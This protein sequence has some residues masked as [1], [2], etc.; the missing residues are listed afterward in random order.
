MEKNT[1]NLAIL[2]ISKS[3][4]LI[5]V[6]ILF[7]GVLNLNAQCGQ[8]TS[9]VACTSSAP[10]VIGNTISCT[11]PS[12]NAGR[13]NFVVNNMVAG[14]TYRIDNCGSGIDTQMTI[15]DALGGNALAYNDDDGPACNGTAAS[16][17]FTPT[18]T[19]TYYIQINKY[20]CATSP[21]TSNGNINV[22]YLTEPSCH[23]LTYCTNSFS[24][25][26][27]TITN[28]TFAGINNDSSTSN[29]SPE[30]E[31]FCYTGNVTKGSS[32][33]ISVNGVTNGYFLYGVMA[34][35][36]WNQDGDFEDSGE[37][38]TIGTLINNS[39]SGTPATAS[40]LVPSTATSGLTTMRVV[41]KYNSYATSC[42][43]SGYGQTEDYLVNVATSTPPTITTLNTVT[44]CPGSSLTIT[45]TNLS[46]ATS[47]TIGNTAATITAN[48]ATSITVTVGNGTTGTVKVTNSSGTATSL[49][50]YTVLPT[51]TITAQP[52]T[53]T[54]VC[55]SSGTRT[56][57]VTA[58]GATSYQWRRNGVNISNNSTYSGTT[59]STLT[60]TNPLLAIA[61]DFDVVISNG[62]CTNTSNAVTLTVNAAP[63]ITSNPSNS[64]ITAG[65]NTS[66]SITASNSPTSYSWQVSTNGGTSWTTISNGGVYSNATTATLN[67]TSATATMDGYLYKARA[68]NSCGN[69]SYS[70]S[71]TLTVSI[72]YCTPSVSSGKESSNYI[73]NVNF[74]GNLVNS[75]NGPTTYS[76]SPR[77]YQDWTSLGSRASQAQEEGVNIFV[78]TAGGANY[79]KAWVD[80]NKDGSFDTSTEVVYQCTNAFLNTTFGFQVPSNTVPGNYRIRL[81]INK[82]G[83]SNSY[84]SCESISYNGETEDYLFTVV[85]NCS[86][87]ITSI[88]NGYN[89]GTGSVALNAVGSS[90][91]TEYRWYTTETGGTYTSTTSTTWNTPSINST[92]TYYV[93]A[94]NGT[95]ESLYR[96]AVVATIKPVPSLTFSNSNPEICGENSII[97]LSASGTNE[98]VYLIDENF[99][100]S[101]ISFVNNEISS[102]NSSATKWQVRTSTYVPSYPTYPVWYPAISSGFGTNKFAMSTSDI[103]SGGTVNEALELISSISTTDFINLT[104]TFK[105]YFSSYYDSNNANNEGV[106]I[107]VNDGT[108]WSSPIMSYLEDEGIGTQFVTK[109]INM[110]AYINK[111][112]LKIRIRYRAGW[113]DG[114][115]VD[116][117][118]LYGDRPL[119]PNFTWTSG[120][121]IDAY[122]DAA[123]TIPYTSGTPIST[124]Y[125]K[126]TLEQLENLNYSFT[127]NANLANGCT[128]SG[129]VNVTNKTKIWKG[130]ENNDWNNANNWS[131]VG[132]PSIDNC[133]LVPD[134][135]TISG[136]GYNAYGKNLNVKSTGTLNVNSD[137]N[138][139]IAEEVIVSS[140]G[141]LQFENNASLIQI[142]N[143]A[144]SGNIIY[145]RAADN[146]KGS[147][148]VYWSSP[149]ANQAI[150]TIYSSPTSGPK[151]KWN[152]LVSNGNGANGNT[153]Q[154]N[155]AGA[156]GNTMGTATGY[157]VRG[158]SSFG[159]TATTINSTFTG[160]PNNGTITKEV[161][162]GS[163]TGATYNGA[164]GVAITNLDDNYNLIGNPYPSAINAL[165]FL[166]TNSSVLN[167]QVKL[168]SHGSSPSTS[169]SNQFYNT[170]AYNYS[171]SDYITIN[172][173]GSTT[174]GASEIIKAG[175]AFFV[176]MQDGPTTTTNVTFNNS[177]RRNASSNPYANNNFFKNSDT[178]KT[179]TN[180]SEATTFDAFERNRI[181][182]DI[183]DSNNN[184]NRA[185]IGYVSGATMAEDN[186][187]DA[188]S[189]SSSMRLYSLINEKEFLIQGRA[190]PFEDTDEVPL[191][192]S[193][194]TAGNYHIAINAIDGLFEGNQEIYLKD[195]LL[196]VYHDLKSA[197]YS[198]TATVG[199]HND[200][201]KLVYKNTVLSTTTFTENEVQIAK[202]NGI[203]DIVS[204]NETMQNVKVFDIR[205]RLIVE[206]NNVD[207]NTLSLDVNSVADQ[208]LI[209]NITTDENIK[210]VKKIL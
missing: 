111:S 17:D 61:G 24:N 21:N 134:S 98:Q 33:T 104:L 50:T 13:R 114:V 138:L 182:L 116:D 79:L 4:L 82:S 65:S 188:F 28:V 195:E 198:F 10:T 34:Y 157:I 81:R 106:F 121:P 137:N 207:N 175:Q 201:F 168:W 55:E 161:S 44:G 14:A 123:C 85:E 49:L 120:L 139:T 125:V 128:T 84:N 149:V 169:N 144:N 196:N 57:S 80:W 197:P 190:L 185:V 127:A 56:I 187:Y 103:T 26:V 22:T 209:V 2:K 150:N 72:S 118:K 142:N 90:G 152:T 29:S 105:M 73:T 192:F 124:V 12:S 206:K 181:W 191:G 172:F 92:T 204:G 141:T 32:Y 36:D 115:A 52:T 110:D 109:S 162:R 158:S 112:T 155:W 159:M 19:G 62:S 189:P 41:K 163:Y 93:T 146:I 76:S 178:N 69:S 126:P 27:R 140:G 88:T 47:V 87:K 6:L 7:F 71:A 63:S 48:T 54:S 208:V 160:V 37:S 133:V 51:P 202:N 176:I 113:C 131:P 180:N 5:T 66:F 30:H 86:A 42:N 74:I 1:P 200:R 194:S 3:K 101:T 143:V 165:E 43:T 171:S 91:T 119:V 25:G 94:Y 89:C 78:N 45:G 151:Y 83:G 132:V 135:V 58:T 186:L 164:N 16:I 8:Y 64:S 183:V 100:G 68:T 95:C 102:S 40:I 148:Y 60:I 23:P 46:N 11:T 53:P 130:V 70:S 153:S 193:V 199:N 9:N 20:N 96:T 67:I 107:E 167:G 177:L 59:G 117:I 99:E 75:D 184:S 97:N 154:G 108:G 122:I 136:S 15:Y 35:F 210:I 31:I 173:T 166:S 205:G 147:D 174:P 18:T 38:Y 170:F 156:S 129:V 39:G 203:I 77:G 179:A 145:K